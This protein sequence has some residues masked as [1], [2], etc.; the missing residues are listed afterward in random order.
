MRTTTMCR[1]N[2]LNIFTLALL[3][4]SAFGQ[5]SGSGTI[6]GT[7]KDPSGAVVPGAAVTIRNTDTGIDRKTQTTEAGIYTATFLRPGH[8][9]I[10]VS[11]PGFSSVLRKD[12]TLQVGQT[13]TVDLSMGIQAAQE[14][15]TV[16]GQAGV[17]DTEKTEVS[18]VVSTAAVENLP[19]AG[20][21]WDAFVLLTPNVTTDGGTGLVSY[22]GISGLYKQNSEDGANNNQAFFSESKGRTITGV[23]YVYSLDS[24]QEFQVSA[25]NYSAELGQA[26]GG[27]VN[28]V[29]KS[30]SNLMHGDLFY[31]LRYPTLNALDPI[32]KAAGNYTQPVHQQQQFGG[33]VGGPIVKDRLFYFLT[34]DGSRKINPI[35]YTS[36]TRFPQPC[37]SPMTAAQCTLANNYAASI[38]GAY[39]RFADNDV[40]FGKLDYQVNARNHVNSSFNWDNFHAP[41]SY[42]T[43][44][45]SPNKS[46]TTT[47]TNV[48]H[49]RAFV[50]NWDSTITP[51]IVNNFRFQWSRDLEITSANGSAPSVGV[52]N[53]LGYGMPNALPRPAF[54]DEHRLQF[55]DVI[56]INHG[57]HMFKA[58]VDVN[59]I[60]E[61]LINLF[62]GGGSYTYSGT[63]NFGLWAADVMGVNLGDGLTGRHF[64]TLVQ[65]TDPATGV[66]KDD[67]YDTDFA[68]FFEDTWKVRSNLTLNLGVRYDL[69]LIPQPPKPNVTTPLTT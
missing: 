9:E 49:N 32:Q 38:L 69:Q 40:A 1:R 54:P 25:A 22:R 43:A 16:N 58:G 48:I 5:T 56:A 64:T 55:N 31:Y 57:K 67:F 12:L 41:N 46:L 13:L 21:R 23:P 42:D 20:R 52:T 44:I 36:A 37:P 27:V 61:L 59:A 26:A 45:T 2:L 6:T 35:S 66:G 47:G 53:V 39:P 17:V 63:G 68:G 7:L 8:Y 30:G 34:Y 33:S 62:N 19:L 60:H 50:A 10:N 24:I 3:A 65:V 29:T 15:I 14:L 18:Q 51:S 11:K 4:S 28:A